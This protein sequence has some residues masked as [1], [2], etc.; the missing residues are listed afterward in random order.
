MVGA[1]LLSQHRRSLFV[2]KLIQHSNKIQKLK[3]I[4]EYNVHQIEKEYDTFVFNAASSI[5]E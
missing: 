3:L 4:K 5:D 1:T 2:A